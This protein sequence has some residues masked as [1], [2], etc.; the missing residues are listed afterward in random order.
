[1]KYEKTITKAIRPLVSSDVWGINKAI[2]AKINE[3]IKKFKSLIN[4]VFSGFKCPPNPRCPITD[5]AIINI[6]RVE[7]ISGAPKMAPTPT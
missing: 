7:S 6:V 5:A 3:I 1:M 2:P 4:P